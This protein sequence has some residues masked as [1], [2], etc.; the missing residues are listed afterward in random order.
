MYTRIYLSE[1]VIQ[2]SLPPLVKK[3]KSLALKQFNVDLNQ[4]SNC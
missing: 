2:Q 3:V 1:D 4:A